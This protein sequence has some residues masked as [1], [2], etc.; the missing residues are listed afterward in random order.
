M[1]MKMI[2]RRGHVGEA[3]VALVALVERGQDKMARG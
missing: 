2:G 1:T 3:L